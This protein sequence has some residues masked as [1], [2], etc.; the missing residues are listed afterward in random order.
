MFLAQ[1][2]AT[3]PFVHGKGTQ[4]CSHRLC[5]YRSKSVI[6]LQLFCCSSDFFPAKM[7]LC[8]AYYA[9][10]KT[11]I[12]AIE[13]RLPLYSGIRT[14]NRKSAE[15][16]PFLRDRSFRHSQ[17]QCRVH[18][19]LSA[20]QIKLHFSS[21]AAYQIQ[22]SKQCKDQAQNT[23]LDWFFHIE[24]K[25]NRTYDRSHPLQMHRRLSE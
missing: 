5:T 20:R 15:R 22:R 3:L 14:I 25:L 11:L 18:S 17:H 2:N 8:R 4:A 21:C 12:I 1:S 13:L 6:T 23:S 10:Y 19:D 16:T 24:S 9:V 7:I